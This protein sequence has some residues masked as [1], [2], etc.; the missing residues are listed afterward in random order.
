[1]KLLLRKTGGSTVDLGQLTAV[2]GDVAQNAKF[3]GAG[4]DD[5]QSGSLSAGWFEK[6]LEA[7]GS[8]TRPAGIVSKD[9]CVYQQLPQQGAM[10]IHPVSGGSFAGVQGK[11]M[12]GDITVGGIDNLIPGNIR[13]G[14]FIG[15]VAG[16]WEGFV[17]NDPLTPYWKGIFAPGQ[18]GEL[19]YNRPATSTYE[20]RA[21]IDWQHGN[22]NPDGQ[23]I[24]M[25]SDSLGANN[26]TI[27]PAFRFV[28]P[29]EMVGVKSVS[30]MYRLPADSANSYTWMVISQG[31]DYY[32]AEKNWSIRADLGAHEKFTIPASEGWVT[33][34]FPI[35]SA[36]QYHY[37]HVGIGVAPSK[38]W[39]RNI[40][41]KFIRLYKQ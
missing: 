8:F 15:S 12:T 24:K 40:D 19:M 41:V 14:A 20:G 35:N 21:T 25:K 18:I 34:T 13:G 9:S 17:N 37:I 10:S 7:N 11:Y 29:I 27:Y 1:M 31:T 26:T 16:T 5:V 38:N 33:R 23:Y 22:A 2:P 32:V 30:I 4:S 39:D 6:E 36:N 3:Y 28:V